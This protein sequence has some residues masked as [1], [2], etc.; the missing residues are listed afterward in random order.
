M[1]F[2]GSMLAHQA[3]FRSFGSSFSLAHIFNDSCRTKRL[4]P[5]NLDLSLLP[6]QSINAL[7]AGTCSQFRNGAMLS[8]E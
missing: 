6:Q 3:E 1:A 7:L 8:D 5:M 2:A 4:K